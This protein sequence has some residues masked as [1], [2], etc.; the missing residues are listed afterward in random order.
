MKAF[1][2]AASLLSATPALAQSCMTMQPGPERRSCIMQMRGN[3]GGMGAESGMM[4][5]PGMGGGPRMKGG[6]GMG[7]GPGMQGAGGGRDAR[8][9]YCIERARSLG[10]GKGLVQSC[11]L[12]GRGGGRR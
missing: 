3:A 5:R 10:T 2:I 12:E 1:V 8:L 7:G 11:M 6:P 4:R 9:A